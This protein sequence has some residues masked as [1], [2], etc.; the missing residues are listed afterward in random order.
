MRQGSDSKDKEGI[1]N[2]TG[3]LSEQRSK[4]TLR[5]GSARIRKKISVRVCRDE[6]GFG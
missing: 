6:T 3:T 5:V 2:P 1:R 4:E